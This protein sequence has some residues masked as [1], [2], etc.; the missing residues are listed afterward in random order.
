MNKE[1]HH[2]CLCASLKHFILLSWLLNLTLIVIPISWLYFVFFLFYLLVWVRCVFVFCFAS[3]SICPHPCPFSVFHFTH[4]LHTCNPAGRL[5]CHQIPIHLMN[6]GI[7]P[8]HQSPT[9]GFTIDTVCFCNTV[10]VDAV[11][12]PLVLCFQDLFLRFVA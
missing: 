12:A 3:L 9:D 8:I 7:A 6:S 2:S 5:V 1:R 4:W 10:I 11:M